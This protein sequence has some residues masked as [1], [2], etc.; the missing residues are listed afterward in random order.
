MLRLLKLAFAF[1]PLLCLTAVVAAV[2]AD[3]SPGD[4]AKS[5]ATDQS[6]VLSERFEEQVENG[7]AYDKATVDLGTLKRL[8]IPEGVEIVRGDEGA[9]V[10]VFMKKTLDFKG[11]PP[12]PMS[13]RTGRKK[14]GCTTKPEGKVL[15]LATFGEW[16]SKEGGA[17]IK[18]LLIVPKGVEVE[19]RKGL[20]GPES[21]A[22]PTSVVSL[23][24]PKEAK[25]GYWYGPTMPSDGWKA[26]RA[27]PDVEHR[28]EQPPSREATDVKP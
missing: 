26:A 23:P 17:R 6:V 2:G 19:M 10:Q 24:G 7:S 8:A 12:E 5:A 4:E 18:L 15:V 28:V 16:R 22:H 14:M 13:I 1:G 20:A 27:V 3:E 25:D 9:E 11:H 21:A